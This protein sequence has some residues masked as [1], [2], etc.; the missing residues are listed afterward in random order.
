MI[1]KV[2]KIKDHV[3]FR[4]FNWK[5]DLPEFKSKNVIYGWNGTGKTT[6]SNLFR[7]L[8]QKRNI[9][10]G[11]VEFI[12]EGQKVTGNNIEAEADLPNVKV[13]NKNFIE[14]TVFSESGDI[15]PIYYVAE[16]SKEKRKKINIL[17][18]E[19][20][21]NIEVIAKKVDAIKRT[22][23]EISTLLIQNAND[24]IKPLLRS[25]GTSNPY[26][27]YNKS[28]FESTL[29]GLKRLDLDEVKKKILSEDQLDVLI[30]KK[31]TK[32]KAF[33]SD[34]ELPFFDLHKHHEN[35]NKILNDT[36][37]SN[38]I[39]ELEN[40]R[41][42][43]SW[44]RAG[45]KIHQERESDQCLFCEKSLDESRKTTLEDHFNQAYNDFLKELNNKI[46]E[47][48]SIS[49]K[50][51]RKSFPQRSDFYE[52]LHGK[53]EQ[54]RFAYE[55]EKKRFS[56][57]LKRLIETLE[58][59]SGK[60]FKSMKLPVS[61]I[62]S[63]KEL[64]KSVEKLIKEHNHITENLD[65]E[66]K[67][68][69]KKIE[70]SIAAKN[71]EKYSNSKKK[72][73]ELK[74]EVGMLSDLNKELKSQIDQLNSEI[75]EH[76]KPASELNADLESYL[77]RKELTFEPFES[78][79]RIKRGEE[80]AENLSEGERTAIAFLYFLKSINDDKFKSKE[81]IVV[82]DD[83]ISSL[84]SNS[85]F[86]AF[87][88]MKDRTEEIDQLFIFTHNHAFF[89]QVKNWFNHLKGQRKKDITKRPASFYMIENR[90]IDESH[91]SAEIV[92]LDKLLH[93][94]DSEYHYLF[95]IIM[96]K[97]KSN[98]NSDLQSNY[99]FPNIA[100]RLLEAFL[101]FKKPSLSHNL[102]KALDGVNFE[103][104]K[105][106]QIIR[107]VHTNSHNDIIS[108]PEHDSSILGETTSVLNHILELI[109]SADEGHYNEMCKCISR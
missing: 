85:I 40:D 47:L 79:Y 42:L 27:N 71:L 82:I 101:A 8:E 93:E 11:E 13:F 63:D 54:V 65:S 75:S 44:L 73:E 25:A 60:P 61:L 14:D 16:G 62:E 100:R 6:L 87:G 88:Y 81:R 18:K 29:I 4:D 57:Y 9:S 104:A 15:A 83:P 37:V 7:A 41:E 74:E 43:S 5:A 51:K 23:K 97:V 28:N 22:K 98:N 109:K 24:V 69:R 33:I 31:D 55:K 36:V 80:D 19:V 84:D 12:I 30:E 53:F 76:R 52:H 108:E 3:I 20:G 46:E 96:D 77:G 32:A 56:N 91:R 68:A 21:E 39:K 70:E 26:N 48:T 105:K 1:K 66:N 35:V 86:H 17:E 90:V 72:E 78:G 49:E 107:F 92:Q 34:F 59:K 99:H 64:T 38:T 106:N 67:E 50:I 103:T 89:R 94:Y 2:S 45:L 58:E 95:S 10:E 102:Q